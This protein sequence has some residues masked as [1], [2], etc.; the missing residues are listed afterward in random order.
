MYL[1]KNRNNTYYTRVVLPKTLR[2]KGFQF[3]VRISLG[4]K[5]R[6]EAIDLNLSTAQFI[7]NTFKI[8]PSELTPNQF[9]DWF[10]YYL[11]EF[12]KNRNTPFPLYIPSNTEGINRVTPSFDQTTLNLALKEFLESKES[13][14]ISYRSI[15]KLENRIGHFLKWLKKSTFN[16]VTPRL[17]MDY[18]NYLLSLNKSY[19][20]NI[21]YI[22]A[23]RQFFKWSVLMEYSQSNPFEGLR[24]GQ[25]PITAPHEQRSR[26]SSDDLN[27]LFNFLYKNVVKKKSNHALTNYYVS[28]IS[29]YAG[30]RTSESCQLKVESIK[31]VDDIYTFDINDVDAN[32]K[33]KTLN[34]YRSIPIHSNL[35]RLGLLEYVNERK[36]L[37]KT[38]LFDDLPSGDYN[39]WSK[40]VGSRFYR[41]FKKL[42]FEDNKKPTLYGLRHTFI[43]ELQQQEVPEHIVA[44]LSGHTKKGITFGR[45]GK[46]LNMKL[47]KEKIELV[48]SYLVKNNNI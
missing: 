39:D 44:E 38:M 27:T 37:G 3:A 33:L 23:I 48:P 18:R 35:I 15:K 1:S 14:K 22:A 24:L 8:I 11:S 34:A 36:R 19:K 46:R 32:T 20:T 10:N 17:A 41:I 31:K 5:S 7:R 25:K 2:S 42:K 4:T 9:K 29:L 21:E 30:L 28:L 47:L 6:S 43:D 12:N 16:Q 40:P 45:Y 13:E 26:W